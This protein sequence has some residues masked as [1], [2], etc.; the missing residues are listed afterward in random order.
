MLFI[1]G[2]ERY[3]EETW[4]DTDSIS[5]DSS[6]SVLDDSINTSDS[7]SESDELNGKLF[8]K[9]NCEKLFKTKK[10]SK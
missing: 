9:K 2:P 3:I 6:D 1:L 4:T 5:S 10:L 8:Y 7:D